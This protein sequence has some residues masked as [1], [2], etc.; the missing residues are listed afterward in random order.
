MSARQIFPSEQLCGGKHSPFVGGPSSGRIGAVVCAAFVWLFE[1]GFLNTRGV[2]PN[3]FSCVCVKVKSYKNR[4][5]VAQRLFSPA[6]SSAIFFFVQE[7]V[8]LFELEAKS[9]FQLL[10]ATLLTLGNTCSLLGGSM[11]PSW[12]PKIIKLVSVAWQSESESVLLPGYMPGIFLF[13]LLRCM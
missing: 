10:K 7:W 2:E 9:G 5:S 13:V 4:C 3:T 1:K 6:A 8:E 11:E 12:M